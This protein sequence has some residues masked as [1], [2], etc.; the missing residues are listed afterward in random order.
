MGIE[1]RSNRSISGGSVTSRSISFTNSI[2]KFVG[3]SAN[4]EGRIA[5]TDV[6]DFDIMLGEIIEPEKFANAVGY[7]PPEGATFGS[8][9]TSILLAP[10]EAT[11]DG[12]CTVAVATTS[13]LCG[14][15]DVVDDVVDGAAHVVALGAHAYATLT[16]DER[17]EQFA[18][19]TVDFI[20]KDWG[21][22]FNKM[23]YEN[24]EWGQTIN[25]HSV[26]KYD[27]TAANFIR[28]QSKMV[29]EVA[30]SAFIP[31]GGWIAA[32]GF[33]SGSG[34]SAE[35]NYKVQDE[36]GH[37]SFNL[38]DEFQI[39]LSGALGVAKWKANKA[40][41]DAARSLLK[42]IHGNPLVWD[43]V[44]KDTIL[45]REFYKA[46][47]KKA[48]KGKTAVKN[49]INEL[50]EVLPDIYQYASGEKELT[51]A[52]IG[53]TVWNATWY[54]FDSIFIDEFKGYVKT[55]HHYGSIDEPELFEEEMARLRERG[56]KNIMGYTG[57]QQVQIYNAM[58]D[59][60]RIEMFKTL[61]NGDADKLYK[62]LSQDNTRREEIMNLLAS[63]FEGRTDITPADVAVF[64]NNFQKHIVNHLTEKQRL[65][66]AENFAESF[67]IGGVTIED[68]R[69]MI[70]PEDPA[71]GQF[72][73]NF[74]SNLD[75]SARN[76]FIEAL[77]VENKS[78][79]WEKF[80]NTYIKTWTDMGKKVVSSDSKVETVQD[81][82]E[83]IASL[84][85]GHKEQ[86]DS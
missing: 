8:I 10:L 14:V 36:N 74:I 16:G 26:M 63:T 39:G 77:E 11:F 24:T 29:T 84:I 85:P 52:N 57:D 66:L 53:T 42:D 19:D 2:E 48:W 3:R 12:I 35:K 62:V 20:A 25:E 46:A 50:F 72:M 60:E 37:Y 5:S 83:N 56:F 13:I 28:S 68:V 27:S 75:D 61:S 58:S 40:L 86:T 38:V 73:A 64:G 41:G 45:N 33:L 18:Q 43:K 23:I 79:E 32:V 49:V 54:L 80:F 34:A 15:I 30:A 31:G 69:T 76:D 7:T 71:S 81:T 51:A 47:W 70:D 78:H 59:A 17:A 65:S 67:N 82:V 22:E 4:S 21:N 44:M 55:P 9:L 6:M 1:S